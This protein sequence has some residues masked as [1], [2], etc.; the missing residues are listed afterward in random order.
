MRFGILMAALPG[1]APFRYRFIAQDALWM[2]RYLAAAGPRAR[3]RRPMLAWRAIQHFVDATESQGSTTFGEF[4]QRRAPSIPRAPW[5]ALPPGAR[6]LALAVTKGRLAPPPGNQRIFVKPPR[7][8]GGAYAP[9]APRW[10]QPQYEEYEATPGEAPPPGQG[11]NQAPSPPPTNGAQPPADAPDA[12]DAGGGSGGPPEGEPPAEEPAGPPADFNTADGNT[13][14]LTPQLIQQLLATLRRHP[15]R[16][17]MKK[18]PWLRQAFAVAG[19]GWQPWG[20]PQWTGSAWTARPQ[21]TGSAWT[22]PWAGQRP[23]SG[24][25]WSGQPW[26]GRPGVIAGSRGY[27]GPWRGR[28]LISP[29]TVARPWLARRP[30]VQRMRQLARSSRKIGTLL[31][32]RTGR[33]YPVF[34]ARSGGRNY[35]IVTRPRRGMQHEIVLVRSGSLGAERHP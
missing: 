20:G 24:G 2:A 7:V 17:W 1:R 16:Y 13:L 4:V 19:S 11:V 31:S 9:A 26:V 8:S 15:R 14:S 28:P 30:I 10:H 32:R 35:H 27:V 21:W 3:G 34:G 25:T 12:S 18:Y 5:Q 22:R 33:R 6:S 23:W 29:S